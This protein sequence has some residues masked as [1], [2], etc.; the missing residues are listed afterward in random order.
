MTSA[1]PNMF[2]SFCSKN[3]NN[4]LK[5]KYSVENV[6]ITIYLLEPNKSKRKNKSEIIKKKQKIEVYCE[7]ERLH[8]WLET[9]NIFLDNLTFDNVANQSLLNNTFHRSRQHNRIRKFHNS[10]VKI[11]L[12]HFTVFYSNV[13]YTVLCKTFSIVILSFIAHQNDWNWNIQLSTISFL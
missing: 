7:R 13:F 8:I 5:I 9:F 11:R 6:K 2:V 12:L 3:V 10:D 4:W 1:F